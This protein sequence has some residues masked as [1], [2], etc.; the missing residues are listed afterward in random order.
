MEYE[1]KEFEHE[2]FGIIRTV[3]INGLLW[4]VGK[5][6]AAALGYSNTVNAI[7]RHV[8]PE[9]KVAAIFRFGDSTGAQRT[10]LINENGLY[11]L[12]FSGRTNNARLF[13]HW[14]TSEILP[15]KQ[16]CE[17]D[18]SKED[19]E[20]LKRDA[21]MADELFQQLAEEKLRCI[22]LENK[23]AELEYKGEYYDKIL[24][25]E[26]TLIA[27]TI[28]A[29]DYGMTAANMNALLKSYKVQYRTGCGTWVLYS[30]YHNKGYTKTKTFIIPCNEGDKTVT[31]TY[32]TEKGRE[33]IYR[34]L[35]DKG[36]LPDSEKVF[37]RYV[38]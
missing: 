13:K 19:L 34:F 7:A 28:I 4:F 6:I 12:V 27:M 31:V 20:A 37:G 2:R 1:I 8:D 26:E 14:L 5:D 17:T 16:M 3:E 29:K 18:I 21:M 24:K 32:W 35:K 22:A 10:I 25:S 38:K 23:N 36:V 33:F 15:S 11:S 30:K 9:D